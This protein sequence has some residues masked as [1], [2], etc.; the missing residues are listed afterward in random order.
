VSALIACSLNG[1]RSLD[2]HPA[3]PVT[4]AQLAA[5]A[6][7][8]VAAGARS[9]HLHV[10]DADGAESLEPADVAATL[11]AV[12]AAAPGVEISLSTGL[13][14]TG[15]D[16]ERR[17]ELV[18]GWTERPELVS[19]NLSEPGWEELATLLAGRR[20]AVEAGLGSTV[21]AEALLAGSVRPA[22]VLVEID[23]ELPAGEA[24]AAAAAIDAVL[25]AAGSWARRLHHGFG[26]ATWAVMDAAA[27]RGHDV[28]VGLEDVLTLPDGEPA[29]GNAALVA[30]A[31]A[32]Y[33]AS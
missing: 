1:A 31:A 14:I 16:G 13:W 10:R 18:S 19:L 33:A 11:A 24:V 17:A 28:R 25:D 7:A 20:I 2:E 21:D 3:L 32:R 26:P 8:A 27:A 4:P 5:D 12:R 22:R 9:L 30:A 15:G 29:P 23:E 6:R